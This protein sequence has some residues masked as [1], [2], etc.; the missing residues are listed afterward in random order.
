MTK[1]N[2]A[3]IAGASSIALF[4]GAL[5]LITPPSA[6]AY[7]VECRNRLFGG[8]QDCSSSS[9]G[10]WTTRPRFGGGTDIYGRTGSGSSFSSTCSTS[11][12]VTR[13][14]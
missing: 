1:F 2:Q 10:S 11:F 3:L 4:A 6:N 9:G 5:T 8:G 7:E 13:C 12:G 14:Y